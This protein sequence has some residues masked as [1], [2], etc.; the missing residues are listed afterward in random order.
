MAHSKQSLSGNNNRRSNRMSNRRS[1][2]STAGTGV[3]SSDRLQV[4][5]DEGIDRTPKPL[6]LVKP[7]A[8]KTNDEVSSP[9][10]EATSDFFLD[11]LSSTGFSTRA[12]WIS[13]SESGTMTPR[14]EQGEGEYELERDKDKEKDKDKRATAA[15]A[16]TANARSKPESSVKLTEDDLEQN[17][18]IQL[19]ETSTMFILQMP[20]VTVGTESEEMTAV[21]ERNRRY[22]QLLR[23]RLAADK[24]VDA[25]GQ[26][27]SALKK[28]REVQSAVLIT[29]DVSSQASPYD[30]ADA[31]R[32][33]DDGH[34]D[35]ED[36]GRSGGGGG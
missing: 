17:V 2:R 30:I 20:S 27:L 25:E 22:H 16:N 23:T 24:Y 28:S 4:I 31:S 18:F 14:S 3:E 26:T 34:V 21:E 12:G 10:S 19:S 5:D 6:L 8:A 13:G 1:S 32:R 11:H 9:P 35:G 36:E 33:R 29:R 7:A 15:A